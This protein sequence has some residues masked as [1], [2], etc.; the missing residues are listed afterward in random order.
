ML[1]MV[2]LYPGVRGYLEDS[3][4]SKNGINDIGYHKWLSPKR[5]V[6]PDGLIISEVKITPRIARMEGEVILK[7]WDK[8]RR[9]QPKL[10][11][12]VYIDPKDNSYRVEVE[13]FYAC[14]RILLEVDL[15]AQVI[16]GDRAPFVNDSVDGAWASRDII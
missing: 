14:R 12:T 1:T 5:V 13:P 16:P 11:A 10:V 2:P 3:V 9:A 6:G 4:F 15:W 7:V 8:W